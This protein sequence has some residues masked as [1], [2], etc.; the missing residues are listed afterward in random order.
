MINLNFVP[1]QQIAVA[2]LLQC[3]LICMFL[4]FLHGCAPT[5]TLIQGEKSIASYE[6]ATL[7]ERL[8]D[9]NKAYEEGRLVEAEKLYLNIV[10]EHKTL[11]DAWFKLGNIFYRS[12]RYSAAINAYETVLAYD[13]KYEK[14]WYNLALTRRSQS[15]EALNRGIKKIDEKSPFY[16]RMLTLRNELIYGCEDEQGGSGDIDISS[17]DGSM[18]HSGAR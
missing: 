14:A 18:G 5:R 1:R 3:T 7:E 2:Q 4:L 9:A 10:F 6:G 17:G 8:F 11:S 16:S 12:G 15:L 13:I